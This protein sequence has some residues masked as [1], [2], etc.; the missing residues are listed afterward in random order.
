MINGC[1]AKCCKK[2][3]YLFCKRKINVDFAFK[4]SLKIFH[5]KKNK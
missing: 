4:K 3:P 5:M 1:T 2:F